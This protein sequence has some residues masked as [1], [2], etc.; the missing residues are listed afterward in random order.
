MKKYLASVALAIAFASMPAVAQAQ[1]APPMTP[2]TITT[3]SATV[4]FRGPGVFY[5]FVNNGVA[6]QTATAQCFDNASAASGVVIAST[7]ALGASSSSGVPLA[8]GKL[9]KLGATCLASGSPTGSGI[10][11]Y[12]YSIP[13]PSR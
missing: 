4:C 1:S 12:V 5:G 3:G 7:A 2:C 10:D 11:V 8:G 13:Q 9:F 6:A